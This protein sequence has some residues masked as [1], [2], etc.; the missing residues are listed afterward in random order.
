MS[1]DPTSMVA[2]HFHHGQEGSIAHRVLEADAP[3]AILD[4]G[5]NAS[6]FFP[7]LEMIE[8][9]QKHLLELHAELGI[10]LA[11]RALYPALAQKPK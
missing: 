5:S 3:F 1:N 11:T 4:L 9:V 10:K 2:V 6:V 8:V 7:T